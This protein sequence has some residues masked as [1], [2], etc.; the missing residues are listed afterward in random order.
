MTATDAANPGTAL[1]LHGVPDSR[2]GHHTAYTHDPATNR[3]YL[4]TNS[5]RRGRPDKA[6]VLIGFDVTA[7][8]VSA[9]EA[10]GYVSQALHRLIDDCP[11]AALARDPAD[12]ARFTGTAAHP[13]ARLDLDVRPPV[14]RI[15]APETDR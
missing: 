3:L 13:P 9:A 1:A 12:P 6:V 15:D 10:S 11:Y 2:S 4:I 5:D 8:D 14:L 7:A